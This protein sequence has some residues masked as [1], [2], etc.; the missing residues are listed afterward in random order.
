M[1][2]F[3]LKLLHILSATVIFGTGAGIATASPSNDGL[4]WN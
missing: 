4:P 3:V 1:T 2:Y